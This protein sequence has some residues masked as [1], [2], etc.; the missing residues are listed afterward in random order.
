MSESWPQSGPG[1]I[2]RYRAVVV[3]A[4]RVK[5]LRR[6]SKPRVEPDDKKHKDAIIA[7]E[8]VRRG[9]IVFRE[10]ALPHVHEPNGW[11]DVKAVV[12]ESLPLVGS[13]GSFDSF[14]TAERL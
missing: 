8:E 2:S 14:K 13:T 6:G 7:V 12:D 9:L 3:A 10:F 4:L 1:A 11:G 5:Q